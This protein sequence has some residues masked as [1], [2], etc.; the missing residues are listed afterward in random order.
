LYSQALIAQ[1]FQLSNEKTS[2]EQLIKSLKERVLRRDDLGAFWQSDSGFRWWQLPIETHSRLIE[3]FVADGDEALVEELKIWLLNNKRTNSWSTT[4]ATSDAIRALLSG[5]S[6][7][8]AP[9]KAIEVDF[10]SQ[11]YLPVSTAEAGSLYTKYDLNPSEILQTS[12]LEM[13]NSN[14]QPAWIAVFFQY[15]EELD[16]IEAT[17]D[18]KSPLQIT[19][20]VFLE[21]ISK[22]GIINTPLGSQMLDQGDV[23]VVQFELTA[24]RDMEF[25]QLQDRRSAAVEPSDVLSGYRWQGGLGYYQANSDIATNF[26]MDFLPKGTY[27][28]QYRLQVSQKGNFSGGNATIQSMYAP[29]F[30]AHS[31]GERLST[32][33]I[34]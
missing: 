25:V 14:D 29:E 12:K 28:I 17:S 1:I 9:T 2:Y 18:L 4:K 27:V 8:L 3:V 16:K 26:F 21:E 19:K 31:K 11:T 22:G 5:S 13:S 30:A 24:D 10:G 15:F 23:L 7:W 32:T 34:N 6:N 20:R 33:G